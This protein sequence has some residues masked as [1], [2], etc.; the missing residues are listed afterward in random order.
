MHLVQLL[1]PV[2]DN[3][4]R[5]FAASLY[6]DVADELTEK[7]GGVTAYSRSPAEGRWQSGTSE[8]HDDVLVVEVM[9]E[10]LDSAWWSEFRE[11]LAKTFRQKSLVIRAQ[12]IQLL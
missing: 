3:V 1:L 10:Q 4:G 12:D 11:R 7:F 5:R 6:E 8:H 2:A 9:V